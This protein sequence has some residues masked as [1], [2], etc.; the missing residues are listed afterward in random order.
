MT[1]IPVMLKHHALSEFTGKFD[2]QK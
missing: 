1:R 2:R